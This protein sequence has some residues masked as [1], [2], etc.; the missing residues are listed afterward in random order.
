MGRSE[1]QNSQGGYL[2][3]STSV[4]KASIAR[5]ISADYAR[6]VDR[7]ARARRGRAVHREQLDR[8]A[9]GLPL[10]GAGATLAADDAAAD[11]FLASLGSSTGSGP[12]ARG[13]FGRSIRRA[14]DGSGVQS[15][16]GWLTKTAKYT[17]RSSLYYSSASRAIATTTSTQTARKAFPAPSTNATTTSIS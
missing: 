9:R 10:A 7:E 12:G 13:P 1:Q 2:A 15:S 3:R 8:A 17:E 5:L 11:A 16:S 4:I 6:K 14:D